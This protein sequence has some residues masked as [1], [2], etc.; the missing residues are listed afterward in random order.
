MS[1]TCLNNQAPNSAKQF[2]KVCG[3]LSATTSETLTLVVSAQ[4]RLRMWLDLY[5]SSSNMKSCSEHQLT[6][7]HIQ[8]KGSESLAL[9]EP[10]LLRLGHYRRHSKRNGVPVEHG[11]HSIL[12]FSQVKT[13]LLT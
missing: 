6:G 7:Q 3:Q 1:C 12:L 4:V 11:T 10:M 13:L 2:L 9:W 5:K 8:N